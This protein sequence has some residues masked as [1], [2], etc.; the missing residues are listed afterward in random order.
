MI[1]VFSQLGLS[2]LLTFFIYTLPKIPHP[3]FFSLLI[4]T[5]IGCL[6]FCFIFIGGCFLNCPKPDA[7]KSLAIP[8]TPKQSGLLGVIDIS[9]TSSPELLKYFFPIF[10]LVHLIQ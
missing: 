8:L 3:W 1:F 10:F 6:K 4:E 7:A 9:T 2:L 5:L